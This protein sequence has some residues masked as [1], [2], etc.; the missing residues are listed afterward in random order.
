MNPASVMGYVL[1]TFPDLKEDERANLWFGTN[2]RSYYIFV[3]FV[4]LVFIG[5]TVYLEYNSIND[6]F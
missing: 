1:I 5:L 2:V 4:S 3:T 6:M